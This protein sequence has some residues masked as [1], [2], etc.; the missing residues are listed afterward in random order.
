MKKERKW[1]QGEID[2][3]VLKIVH[4]YGEKGITPFQLQGLLPELTVNAVNEAFMRLAR[5][6]FLIV[7]DRTASPGEL[8]IP[9]TVED[10]YPEDIDICN[11]CAFR[12]MAKRMINKEV[13]ADQ[14]VS[15]IIGILAAIMTAIAF[16]RFIRM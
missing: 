1:L 16:V 14:L 12:T 9:A 11:R 15:R 13:R 7:G 8:P 4:R 10:L 3:A 2:L 5:R 6:G